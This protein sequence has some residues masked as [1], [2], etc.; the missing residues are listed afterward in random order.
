MPEKLPCNVQ[1][2]AASFSHGSVGG[3]EYGLSFVPGV[4]SQKFRAAGEKFLQLVYFKNFH[5]LFQHN[6]NF[7]P[8]LILT[9]PLLNNIVISKPDLYFEGWFQQCS[10][11]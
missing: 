11:R 4:I 10:A 1:E 9:P 8:F 5:N 3:Y 6:C 7:T 2:L